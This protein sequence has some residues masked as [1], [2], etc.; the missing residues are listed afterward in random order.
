MSRRSLKKITKAKTKPG[1]IIL[2]GNNKLICG[3]STKPETLE[4][5]FGDERASM[6]MS[7][8]I[9]NIAIDYNKGIG[10]KAAYGGTVDDKQN[11]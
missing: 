4:R 11:R 9:Y 8:P 3:D 7:D 2:L 10:G 1:D 5:L 6:I